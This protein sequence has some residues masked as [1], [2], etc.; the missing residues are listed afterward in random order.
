VSDERTLCPWLEAGVE[1]LHAAVARRAAKDVGIC[2]VPPGS[3]RS[4]RIDQYNAAVGAPVGSYWCASAVSAWFREAGA[5]TPP[6]GAASCDRWMTWAKAQGLWRSEPAIGRAV[7]Y[8]KPGDASHIGVV[9]RTAPHLLSM[10]GNT[11]LDGY[12]RNG[13]VVTLKYV[14]VVRVLGYIEPKAAP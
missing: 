11:T 8:G 3:N 5:M 14:R 10:E 6:M 1:A 12:S 13:E 9:V 2:E 7:V 4:G